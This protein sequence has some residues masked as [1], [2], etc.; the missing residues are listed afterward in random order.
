MVNASMKILS[1]L[2]FIVLTAFSFSQIAVPN[3]TAIIQNFDGMNSG[4]SLPSNWRMHASTSSPSWTGASNSITQQASSGSPTAGGTYNW[5]STASERA[6]GAMTSGGFASPNNLLVFFSNTH[7]TDNITQLTVAYDAERYRI[8]TASASIE[9]YYS[10]N[11]TSWT[12]VSAGDVAPSSFPTAT[13]SY[14]FATPLTVSVGSFSITGLNI[15][16]SANFYLRWNINTTGSNSQGIGIDN[17]SLT[18]THT[19]IIPAPELNLQTSATSRAC[20]FTH[21]FG[22]VLTSSSGT[23]ALTIQNT[24]TADLTISSLALSGSSDYTLNSP[25]ATSFTIAAGGSQVINIDFNPTSGGTITGALTIGNNDSDEGSCV[26]NLTGVGVVPAPELNLQTSATNRAC[27]FTH[28]FGSVLTSSSGT[29][30]LTIQNTGTADL[31]ISSFALSGS[32]DYSLNTPPSLPLTIAAGGSQV[33]NIDFN[34]TSGGTITGALTI[35][36]NDSDEGSCVVNLTGVGVLPAP[37]LNLQTSATNR[38][39]GFT[40]NFG[41]VLTTNSGTIALTIQN[42]GTAD[43][44]I[45]SLALSGSTDYTLNSPPATSFTITAGG[46][47]VINIDFNPTSGGTITGALTIGNNDSD[48]GPCVVNLT[49]VGVVPAPELNL[50]TASTNRACGFTHNFGSVLTS[51]SGTVALTIQNT[52]TADLTISSL[53]LSGSADYTLNS[54]P[55]TPLTIVAG[56]SQVININFNPTAGGTIA[57]VLTIGSNDSDEGTCLVNLTG[58]GIAAVPCSDLFFSEYIEGS[59]N[60]KFLE[61]YNPTNTSVNLNNYRILIY[62]N[63]SPTAT[64]TINL[65]GTLAPGAVFIVA[66]SGYSTTLYS[67]SVNLST[68]SLNFNGN[69]AVELFKIS[70]SSSS[71]IIGRIGQ[72]PGAAWT[73]GGLSTENRT[74]IRNATVTMGVLINPSSGFPSLATEWTGLAQDNV[75]NLGTHNASSCISN[76]LTISALSSLNYSVSCTTNDAGSIDY[77][78]SG[79]FN[80]GNT[81][82]LQLSDPFG[83]FASPTTIFTTTT[84][85]TSGTINFTIPVGTTAGTGY[86]IRLISSNPSIITANNGSNIT[87][88]NTDGGC[89]DADL[90]AQ[91]IQ[92][93]VDPQDGANGTPTNT[94]EFVQVCNVCTES[95]DISCYLLCFTDNNAGDRRGECFRIPSGTILAPG[96]CYLMGGNGTTTTTDPAADWDGASVILDL[97]WHTC[98]TC[99]SPLNGSSG[100][101]GVLNDGGEDITFFNETG[102]LLSA[103]TYGGSGGAN[104]SESFTIGASGSCPSTPITIPSSASHLNVGST[105]SA[106]A[107]QEFDEG[108]L[109]DCATQSWFFADA[110][111]SGGSGDT[112]LDL[113][114]NLVYGCPLV[115]PLPVELYAFN[116]YRKDDFNEIYWITNT[117]RNNSYFTL[118]RSFNGLDFDNIATIQGAGN[119]TQQITYTYSDPA[120]NQGVYYKLEQHDLD[121]NS[122]MYGT[123]YLPGKQ[124]EFNI[125]PNPSSGSFTLNIAQED[126]GGFVYVYDALGKLI[127]DQMLNERLTLI[128]L[129][130]VNPGVYVIQMGSKFEKIIIR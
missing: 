64:T 102:N 39:C 56:G 17:F 103:V 65:A 18:A 86:R 34:P 48:E 90:C 101:I 83:N 61:I 28:N 98:G 130:G 57:G 1:F 106:D 66:N 30:A 76:N 29:V 118:Y 80:S 112:D 99:V 120:Y 63:G 72:D 21:N 44:T 20:G 4:T 60:N 54:P 32:T 75:T 14:T 42:T 107:G 22:S 11:G 38:A 81:L 113:N 73:G 85:T 125:F 27:G 108:W 2:V 68:G 119:S 15:A 105:P 79:T 97:N 55:A 41:N 16:P 93:Q 46:S 122:K 126:L 53:V 111:F 74:L 82:T 37:E 104:Y 50:Q 12:S 89:I 58:V 129:A 6:V 31:T 24:G 91:I 110:D 33:I 96:E 116:G 94:G 77:S 100:F 84:T 78:Y 10:L 19:P 35:E 7:S 95:V 69:D 62:G 13:S 88:V 121:G 114:P 43:L 67:G 36:N 3:S 87:I 127:L 25:P 52:G 128:E 8:N 71:D 40:H 124:G 123:I 115:T 92:F 59:S 23:I 51:S 117:E 47:Q 49:G 70:T 26:V 5:G 109:F 9:F 45:S